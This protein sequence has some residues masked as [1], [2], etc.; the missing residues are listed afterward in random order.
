MV[1][2]E[3]EFHCWQL[4]LQQL[5]ER[6]RV[7]AFIER[8]NVVRIYERSQ[9]TIEFDDAPT[10]TNGQKELSFCHLLSVSLLCES[11]V[12]TKGAARHRQQ[13]L[14]SETEIVADLVSG[15]NYALR[16]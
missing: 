14:T 2:E 8:H 5:F 15:M 10:E 9:I 3:F 7:W 4:P 1:A 16:F 12:L 13:C 6:P 11:L